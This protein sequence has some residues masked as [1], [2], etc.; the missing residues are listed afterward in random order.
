V[1]QNVSFRIGIRRELPENV[2]T[3]L[4]PDNDESVGTGVASQQRRA[5]DRKIPN[6]GDNHVP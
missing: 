3:D 4:T 2:S 1:D 6:D 5:F